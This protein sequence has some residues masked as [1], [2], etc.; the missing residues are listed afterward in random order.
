MA[1]LLVHGR[2]T[3][4]SALR[5]I[6]E[7]RDAGGEL[8]IMEIDHRLDRKQVPTGTEFRTYESYLTEADYQLLDDEAAAFARNWYR[9]DGKDLTELHG[10]SYG[11]EQEYIVSRD[12]CLL[13]KNLECARRTFA[14]ER[15][16][17]AYV[18]EGV[19][20]VRW[21]W[22]AQAEARGIPVE[23]LPL[24]DPDAQLRPHSMNVAKTDLLQR[25]QRFAANELTTVKQVVRGLWGPRK[26]SSESGPLD[27]GKVVL[28]CRE[29]RGTCARWFDELRAE[30][31]M[32]LIPIEEH[33]TLT[34]LLKR[35]IAFVWFGSVWVFNR[36]DLKKQPIFRYK[37]TDTW[38]YWRGEVRSR[39]VHIFR[40]NYH[41]LHKIL[42]WIRRNRVRAIIS[43]WHEW[44]LFH[45]VLAEAAEIPLILFQDSWLPGYYFPKGQREF[46]RS[47]HLL[48]W[49]EI[50][51]DGSRQLEPTVVHIVGN[52]ESP[53]LRLCHGD[54]HRN[55]GTDR[56]KTKVLLTH[57]C[58]GAWNAFHS[59]L[60]TNDMLSALIEAAKQLPQ[61]EFLAKIHPLVD[62][63][64]NEL[65]GRWEEIRQW[66]LEQD[67]PNLKV[68]ALNA[69]M[70]D[71]LQQAGLV[72]TYYSLTAVEAIT[73]GIPVTMMNLTGKRDLFPELVELAGV[74]AVRS[75]DEF[76]TLVKKI[77]DGDFE[78]NTT[79]EALE[80][81]MK[82]IFGAP[83]NVSRTIRNIVVGET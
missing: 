50:S 4:G 61:V 41:R 57:Q 51:A 81:L 54:S 83:V 59:P 39:M 11:S 43:T 2:K 17:R 72:V 67:L 45:Y 16:D 80:V 9:I 12:A 52:P 5:L 69:G 37:D 74:P 78:L 58:W 73:Q 55:R 6:E 33:D 27:R 35:W 76:T 19:S 53:T 42:P 3:Y 40:D 71:A 75:L 47:H 8:M 28:A 82:R 21:A 32:T 25:L 31:D 65:P 34:A 20:M 26:K 63:F 18:G 79:P 1:I 77:H 64:N 13:F 49:G 29:G 7:Q 66:L 68:L 70:A 46:I 48:V 62:D 15:I 23:L 36:R 38:P 14:T 10:T 30:R 60:D 24:D 44:S 22:V 56:E